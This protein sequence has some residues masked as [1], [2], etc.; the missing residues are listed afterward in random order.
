MFLLF[1][2]AH[3]LKN[4]IVITTT[5]TTTTNTTTITRA[6]FFSFCRTCYLYDSI[7]FVS[8]KCIGQSSPRRNTEKYIYVD[9]LHSQKISIPNFTLLDKI[10]KY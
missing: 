3:V 5:T 10:N 8:I 9:R 4:I 2:I 7:E 6:V 1:T